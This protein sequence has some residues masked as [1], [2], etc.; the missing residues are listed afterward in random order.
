MK[1][2]RKKL[3]HIVMHILKELK[4]PYYAG[5]PA[6][7][8]FF[9]L[10]SFVPL[11]VLLGQA[12]GVLSVS[13]EWLK[14]IIASQAT[15]SLANIVNEI[16]INDPPKSMN[17]ILILVI[18]WASSRGQYS[19]IRISNYAYEHGGISYSYIHER[20]RAIKTVVL[21]L[22]IIVFSL[23]I[24]VYGEII[25]KGVAFYFDQTRGSE[26]LVKNIWFIIRWPIAATI[27]L[28]TIGFTYMILPAEKLHIRE[29]I[30]G[31]IFASTF[32]LLASV[33]YS[34]YIFSFKYTGLIYGSLATV[35]ALML[36]LYIIGFIL[37]IGILFNI[38]YRDIVEG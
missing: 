36:W 4:D 35:V 2:T 7:L 21:T 19:L 14:S 17:I 24:L 6:E 30:P 10:L 18:A 3:L 25:I 38:A 12:L 27:Y 37:V 1:F 29:I 5:A 22:I 32:I 15:A 8:A 13:T 28:F 34:Q 11:T 26:F 33:I 16:L 9:F 20:I 23:T 31:T